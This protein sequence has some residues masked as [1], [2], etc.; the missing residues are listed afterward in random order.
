MSNVPYT[1]TSTG[2]RILIL[3]DVTVAV[4]D[5]TRVDVCFYLIFKVLSDLPQTKATIILANHNKR[6]QRVEARENACK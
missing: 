5:V 1:H 6:K 3:K 2:S 4:L